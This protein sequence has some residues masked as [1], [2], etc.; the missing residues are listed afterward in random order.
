MQGCWPDST[1]GTRRLIP[2]LNSQFHPN[3]NYT[4]MFVVSPHT[5]IHTYTYM[6][7]VVIGGIYNDTSFPSAML[8]SNQKF[9]NDISA[10]TNT[11]AI[12]VNFPLLIFLKCLTSLF[13]AYSS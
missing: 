13:A 8:K 9:K 12:V 11:A 6:G 3:V 2:L 10:H 7:I 4:A 5:D 1:P